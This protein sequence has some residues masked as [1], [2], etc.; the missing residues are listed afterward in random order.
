VCSFAP[1]A[2]AALAKLG[3]A[4]ARL[5]SVG[6]R[7]NFIGVLSGAIQIKYLFLNNIICIW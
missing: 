3:Y 5:G 2:T 4:F 1:L 7:A 6:F